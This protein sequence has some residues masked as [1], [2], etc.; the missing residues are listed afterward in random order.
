MVS[1]RLA[2]SHGR[3]S[4]PAHRATVGKVLRVRKHAMRRQPFKITTAD[5]QVIESMSAQQ[6]LADYRRRRVAETIVRDGKAKIRISTI[7]LHSLRDYG[8]G[9]VALAA[10]ARIDVF[11]EWETM[12]FGGTLDRFQDRTATRGAAKITHKTIV[13]AVRIGIKI[14]ATE[15]ARLRCMHRSYRAR[16][17]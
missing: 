3:V 8:P 13:A 1:S 7:R 12:V 10:L 2:A 6:L 9:I 4:C 15:R 14:R 5:G 17:A 16:W 11:D